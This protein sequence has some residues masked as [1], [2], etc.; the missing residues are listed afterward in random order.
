M[1]FGTDS[2]GAGR[3]R[4]PSR[5]LSGGHRTATGARIGLIS[6]SIFLT[7]PQLTR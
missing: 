3:G 6:P 2:A 7:D 5:A 1:G 4:D